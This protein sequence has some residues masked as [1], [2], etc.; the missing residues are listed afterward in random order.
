MGRQYVTEHVFDFIGKLI[1]HIPDNNKHNIRYYGFYANASSTDLDKLGSLFKIHE[2]I[3][4]KKNLSWRYRLFISY[5]YDP[6]W[7][8]CGHYMHIVLS[9]CY[10][11]SE[12]MDI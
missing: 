3:E 10:F 7:C 8:E 9:E 6:I 4:M 11:P 5:G 12:R 2:I 1:V